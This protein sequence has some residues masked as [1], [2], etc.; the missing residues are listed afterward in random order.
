MK[1]TTV[2]VGKDGVWDCP[3]SESW[4][5]STIVHTCCDDDTCPWTRT[6]FGS[7]WPRF[8]NGHVLAEA[9]RHV[10]ASKLGAS[11]W[12]WDGW[13]IYRIHCTCNNNIHALGT[14]CN[15]QTEKYTHI[16]Q[17]LLPEMMELH[18]APILI[19]F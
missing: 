14:S 11:R 8:N 17:L 15:S 9:L 10:C 5:F 3:V 6:S 13:H 7:K 4:P 18:C 2:R 12:M 16:L 1:R 19:I